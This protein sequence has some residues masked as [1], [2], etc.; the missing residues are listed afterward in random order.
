MTAA[1]VVAVVGAGASGTLTAIHLAA[2]A[3]RADRRID[4]VLI[5]DAPVGQGIAY[6]TS[7]RRHRLNVPAGRMS[8]WPDDPTHFVRWLVTHTDPSARAGTFAARCDYGRYLHETLTET[9]ATNPQVHLEFA[10]GRVTALTGHG[11]RLRMSLDSARGRQVDAAVLATG[12]GAPSTAWAPAELA[13]SP[14]FVADPWAA[15]ALRDIASGRP[16]LLVGS[17]L[18]MADVAHV[19]ADGHRV[20]HTVSRHGLL[21][22]AH[23]TVPAAPVPAPAVPRRA[24]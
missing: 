13:R 16:V 12:N 6:S 21:P 10:T 19:L 20:L 18:T 15:H 23:R 7:D 5:D 2:A 11:R 17:G 4:V 14:Y 22:L 24:R 8:V 1:S 9:V 3:G